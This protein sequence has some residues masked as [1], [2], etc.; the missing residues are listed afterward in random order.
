MLWETIPLGAITTE[1]KNSIAING[2]LI[3]AATFVLSVD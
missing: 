2:S 1:N 3:P